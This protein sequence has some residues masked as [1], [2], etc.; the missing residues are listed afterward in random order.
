MSQ[1]AHA[2]SKKAGGVPGQ[3]GNTMGAAYGKLKSIAS[4]PAQPVTKR[5]EAVKQLGALEKSA[6]EVAGSPHA[7]PAS[8][9]PK[10]YNARREAEILGHPKPTAASGTAKVATHAL[11]SSGHP[12]SVDELMKATGV[13]SKVTMMTA[14][15]DLKNPKYAGKL[16]ALS[17]EK[18]AS[19]MYRVTKAPEG[20][21]KAVGGATAPAGA[22]AAASPLAAGGEGAV[23]D[24][25]AVVTGS[26][27]LSNFMPG[28]KLKAN[29]QAGTGYSVL[30]HNFEGKAIVQRGDGTKHA[31]EPN[32]LAKMATKQKAPASGPSDPVDKALAISARPKKPGDDKEVEFGASPSGEGLAKAQAVNQPELKPAGKSVEQKLAA[33]PWHLSNKQLAQGRRPDFETSLNKGRQEKAATAAATAPNL[34]NALGSGGPKPGPAGGSALPPRKGPDGKPGSFKP[35]GMDRS[36]VRAGTAAVTETGSWVAKSPKGA[37]R[38]FGSKQEAL[39]HA[40]SAP[41]SGPRSLAKP[42]PDGKPA[43]LH[44]ALAA[45]QRRVQENPSTVPAAERKTAKPALSARQIESK[46]WAEHAKEAESYGVEFDNQGKGSTGTGI[47]ST[48]SHGDFESEYNHKTGKV[49]HTWEREYDLPP[50]QWP[51]SQHKQATIPDSSG[52]RE[53]VT[54][55]GGDPDG[56]VYVQH[57]DGDTSWQHAVG[58]GLEYAKKPGKA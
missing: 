28:D 37:F 34:H 32:Q 51:K 23:Q 4:D 47:Y 2:A 18:D 50:K 1:A 24:P 5:A 17:I 46:V 41:I 57:A 22:A 31:V 48:T 11:L 6:G 16:G 7:Q 55:I 12:F 35:S 39:D 26:H 9:T 10:D 15:S 56:M 29:G 38:E 42:G 53:P 3:G 43:G 45:A 44:P 14:I 58:G 30:G 27:P 19:G 33:K 8:E 40:D 52:K 36:E 54:V 20:G 49:D 25:H 21:F 13:T